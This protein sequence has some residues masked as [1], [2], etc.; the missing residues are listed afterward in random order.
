MILA[1]C[2]NCNGIVGEKFNGLGTIKNETQ[3]KADSRKARGCLIGPG[4]GG[5]VE[6]RRNVRRRNKSGTVALPLS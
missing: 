4:A 6:Q 2:C 1:E 5:T 3:L